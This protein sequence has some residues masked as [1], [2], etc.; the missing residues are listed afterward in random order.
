V[1]EI[2]EYSEEIQRLRQDLTGAVYAKKLTR[3]NSTSSLR[4]KLLPSEDVN[5]LASLT[6]T[7]GRQVI[8][9]HQTIHSLKAEFP[10]FMNPSTS[11]P[12]LSTNDWT[13]LKKEIETLMN[14]FADALNFIEDRAAEEKR[15][16]DSGACATR[17]EKRIRDA[18]PGLQE[19]EV[20]DEL[21]AAKREAA[22]MGVAKLK[23]SLSRRERASADRAGHS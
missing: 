10:M 6:T 15:D 21:K 22:K 4:P 14:T 18:E 19:A 23:V 13:R 7:T 3:R 2:S 9:T 5:R 11:A 17:M 8:L 16:V 12:Q 1:D 20:I